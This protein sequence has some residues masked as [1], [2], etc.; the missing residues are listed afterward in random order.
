MAQ[1]HGA[2]AN[3]AEAGKHTALALHS[4][5]V[6]A[7]A[8]ATAGKSQ[9]AKLLHNP[10]VLFGLGVAV[11]YAVHKYRKEIIETANRAAEQ[12][13]DF[14]LQQRENLEDLVAGKPEAEG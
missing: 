8:A 13:K 9:L 11:G 7:G 5:A 4:A 14:V 6:S 1:V 10:F 3:A 2:A 12:S